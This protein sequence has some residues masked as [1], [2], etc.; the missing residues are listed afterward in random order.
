MKSDGDN[1]GE[2]RSGPTRDGPTNFS[3]KYY[4]KDE[5]EIKVILLILSREILQFSLI[6]RERHF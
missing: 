6:Q 2:T 5:G 1:E 4:Q 3:Q